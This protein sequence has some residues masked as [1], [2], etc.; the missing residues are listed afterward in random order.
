M[1]N[2][3]AHIHLNYHK[4][5]RLDRHVPAF[6][7]NSNILSHLTPISQ[8]NKLQQYKRSAYYKL[9]EKPG[10]AMKTATNVQHSF[11]K[12]DKEFL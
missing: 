1:K 12:T 2:L 5:L 7:G 6:S 10:L 8:A 9:V 11:L 3:H 4:L